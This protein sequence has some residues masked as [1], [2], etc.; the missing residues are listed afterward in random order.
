MSLVDEFVTTII[1][2]PEFKPM[3]KEGL[4]DAKLIQE[5]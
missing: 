1:G 4:T 3:F 5:H 2:I